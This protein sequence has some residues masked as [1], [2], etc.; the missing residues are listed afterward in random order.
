MP[1]RGRPKKNGSKPRWMLQ[2]SLF[3]ML[4]FHNAKTR[5]LKHSAAITETVAV[6]RSKYRN[7]PVSAT[8]VKRTLAAW[9][10]RDCKTSFLVRDSTNS[11]TIHRLPC[12]DYRPTISI[13]IGLRPIYPRINQKQNHNPIS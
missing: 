11:D 13:Y 7:L 6:I 9:M 1:P 8:E 4:E 10:P 12:G 2:R 5:G 3:I